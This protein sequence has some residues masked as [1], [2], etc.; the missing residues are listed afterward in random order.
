MSGEIRHICCLDP[1]PL[2][3]AA[4]IWVSGAAGSAMGL[5]Q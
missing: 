3:E 2:T 4:A 1:S 5:G